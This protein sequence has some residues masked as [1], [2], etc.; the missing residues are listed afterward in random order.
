MVMPMTSPV[1]DQN[2]IRRARLTSARGDD[3]ELIGH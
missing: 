3:V 2:P 1:A